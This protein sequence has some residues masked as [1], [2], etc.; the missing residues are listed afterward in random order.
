MKKILVAIAVIAIIAS[1]FLSSCKS[2]PTSP[3]AT[4]TPY[5][6]V[7]TPDAFEDDDVSGD[8]HEITVGASRSIKV[9]FLEQYFWD[10]S[11]SL[12]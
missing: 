3:D 10:Y 4:P 2:G 1:F 9:V 8:A 11:C 12:F 5:P 6:T 7:T